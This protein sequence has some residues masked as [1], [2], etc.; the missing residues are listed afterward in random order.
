MAF[1]LNRL[2]WHKRHE[3][4]PKRSSQRERSVRHMAVLDGSVFFA[5]SRRARG[6]FEMAP[7]QR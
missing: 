2:Q 5:L 4:R 1:Q 6:P 7:P 3:M